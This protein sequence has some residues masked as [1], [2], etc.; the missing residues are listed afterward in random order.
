MQCAYNRAFRLDITQLQRAKSFTKYLVF[1]DDDDEVEEVFI[2]FLLLN[3][4]LSHR[5][6]FDRNAVAQKDFR[7]F[8]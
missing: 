1:V 2:F 3:I 7:N 6:T 8:S 5:S 4:L